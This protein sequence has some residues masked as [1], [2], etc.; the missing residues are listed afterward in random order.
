MLYSEAVLGNSFDVLGSDV[1][2]GKTPDVLGSADI[3]CFKICIKVHNNIVS[4]FR[5]YQRHINPNCSYVL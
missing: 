5:Y 1:V 4:A 3:A 2:S